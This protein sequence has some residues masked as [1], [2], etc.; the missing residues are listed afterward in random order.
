MPQRASGRLPAQ[1]STPSRSLD[2]ADGFSWMGT[3]ESATIS[4]FDDFASPLASLYRG[5]GDGAAPER[6]QFRASTACFSLRWP[7]SLVNFRRVR[8]LEMVQYF[9]KIGLLFLPAVS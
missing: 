1:F 3:F 4:F 6:V 2:L 7:A 8:V 9:A 5:T